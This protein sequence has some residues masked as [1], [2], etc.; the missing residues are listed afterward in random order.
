M[1]L[2]LVFLL[3]SEAL[4]SAHW[5]E[6][7]KMVAMEKI[8]KSPKSISKSGMF[9]QPSWAEENNIKISTQD[10]TT[11]LIKS[12]AVSVRLK[13]ILSSLNPKIEAK[14]PKNKRLGDLNNACQDFG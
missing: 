8:T 4:I 10:M 11:E 2:S 7:A 12:G 3:S 5:E 14:S 9:D 13:I 1:K 6:T